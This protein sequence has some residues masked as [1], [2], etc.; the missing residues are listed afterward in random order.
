ML[1]GRIRW[2]SERKGFGFIIPNEG[3]KDVFLHGENFGGNAAALKTQMWIAYEAID[4]PEGP[5]AVRAR[6]CEAKKPRPQP[7]GVKPISEYE[8]WHG[9]Q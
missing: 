4:T 7:E 3:G 9:T 2:F 8:G 5:R 1:T 6:L